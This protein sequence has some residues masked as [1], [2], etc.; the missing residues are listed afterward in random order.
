MIDGFDD[1]NLVDI[2]FD[3]PASAT[4]DNASFVDSSLVVSNTVDEIMYDV[5]GLSTMLV[6]ASSLLVETVISVDSSGRNV[7]EVESDI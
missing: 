4:V 1:E 2:S 5:L 7:A 6:E 3:D